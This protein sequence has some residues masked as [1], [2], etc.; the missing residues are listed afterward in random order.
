MAGTP[1]FNPSFHLSLF[2]PVPV[3]HYENFPVASFLLP[4]HLR[5]PIEVIYHFA[6]SADDFADEGDWADEQR[7]AW[8][9]EYDRELAG[10]AAGRQ[11]EKPLFRD[12]AQVIARHQLPISLFHDLVDAFRQDVT[13]TRYADF[14]ELMD[15]CRRSADPIGRLLLYLN[16]AA[17]PEN[18]QRSDA[19]CS[20]LQLINH[21]QDV[22]IDWKKNQ[23]NDLRGRVY[24]PQN[25]L[26]RFGLAD[27]DIAA[28]TSK[29]AWTE[30][31]RFQTD[32]ARALL[33]SGKPLT[34]ALAGRFALELKVIVAG[35][36]RI[37]DKIDAA[38]GDVF[39]HR[40]RLTRWDWLQIVPAALL[41]S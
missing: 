18:L 28:S 8:L 27:A 29:P 34:S 20:A 6:R 2:R 26:A 15:Y 11:S 30:M 21:W 33:T 31:M 3:D 37:L 36:A 23:K 7:L 40:P 32:R 1:A 17:T 10:I 35:G 4:A 9:A 19:I 12:L 25:D 24:L 39:R 16:G 5:H 14:A 13:Q 41:K 22:A 38:Q